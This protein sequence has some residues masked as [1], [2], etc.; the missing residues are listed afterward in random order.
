MRVCDNQ[1]LQQTQLVLTRMVNYVI[2]VHHGKTGEVDNILGLFARA[3]E[4]HP[5]GECLHALHLDAFIGFLPTDDIGQLSVGSCFL[6]D[7]GI[8]LDQSDDLVET[9]LLAD[10]CLQVGEK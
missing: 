1:L 4:E 8:V 2:Q 3:V 10:M 6:T 5:Y 9:Y 7:G